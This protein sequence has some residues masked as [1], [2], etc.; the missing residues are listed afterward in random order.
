MVSPANIQVTLYKPK[1]IYLGIQMYI[2]IQ[3]CIKYSVK[4]RHGF[5]GEWEGVHGR[6]WR[7]KIEG[8]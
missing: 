1:R 8:K 7:E 4:S 5:K 3:I 2:P 6:V